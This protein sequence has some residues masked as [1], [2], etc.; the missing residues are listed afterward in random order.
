LRYPGTEADLFAS[1]IALISAKVKRVVVGTR[2]FDVD[3]RLASPFAKNDW[4]L[5]DLNSCV[6]REDGT[7]PVI[8]RD[9]VQVWRNARF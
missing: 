7:Q 5:E 8:L 6:M 4:E 9:G 3:R 2:S 1:V